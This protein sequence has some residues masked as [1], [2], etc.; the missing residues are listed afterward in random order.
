MFIKHNPENNSAYLGR[1]GGGGACVIRTAQCV[2]I[3]VWNKAGQMSNG[4]L[5]N[6]GMCNELVENMGKYLA[7]SGY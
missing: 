6:A 1:E 3:G 2:V 5:Q 4:K 7:T